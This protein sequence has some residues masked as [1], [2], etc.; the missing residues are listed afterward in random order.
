[1][2]DRDNKDL[3]RIKSQQELVSDPSSLVFIALAETLNLPKDLKRQPSRN[4]W[5]AVPRGFSFRTLSAVACWHA[6]HSWLYRAHQ[7]G[8]F[9]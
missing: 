5:V 4:G 6:G 1:M 9:Y 8:P 7:G 3:Q 2:S